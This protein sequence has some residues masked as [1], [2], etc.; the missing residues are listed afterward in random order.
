MKDFRG[1]ICFLRGFDAELAIRIYAAADFL[2]IPSR[3]EPCGL[4]DYIAQLFGA[5][6]VV[7]H[8][9]GLVKVVDGETGFAYL[10]NNP[11]N[12]AEVLQRSLTIFQDSDIIRQMQRSAVEKIQR[13]Y[14]WEK[15]MKSYIRL[16]KQS[17]QVLSDRH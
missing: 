15:V 13:F 17:R 14:T 4:T 9:G 5:L 16:Y 12:L 6:P 8:V 7:H 1:R 10:D 2:V 3:Y 11:E